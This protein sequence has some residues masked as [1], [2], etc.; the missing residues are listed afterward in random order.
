[1]LDFLHVPTLAGHGCQL[2]PPRH[3]PVV[4]SEIN[5]GRYMLEY[6]YA[7][8]IAALQYIEDRHVA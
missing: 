1:M 6:L 8:Y 3:R 5:Q 4:L 7:F 2:C